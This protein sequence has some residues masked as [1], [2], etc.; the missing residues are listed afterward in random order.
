MNM[1]TKLKVGVVGADGAF[2]IFILMPG[3][4]IRKS[5]LSLL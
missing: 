5:K 4:S 3:S 1:S 2:N